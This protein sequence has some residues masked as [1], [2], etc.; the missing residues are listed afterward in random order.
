M[1]RRIAPLVT[2]F[3]AL[4]LMAGPVA[5][6]DPDDLLRRRHRDTHRIAAQARGP[7]S[8][9]VTDNFRVVGMSRLG[10]GVPNGDVFFYD[11]N[12][13]V[14]KYAYVGS[15]SAQCTGAGAKIVDVND[16][17]R[18]RWVGSVGRRADSSSEDIVVRRIGGRDV[19]GIGVQAC[20]RR[21]SDGLAL[22][23]VTNPR[24]P[25]ALSFFPTPGGVHE[26]DLVVR[27]DGRAL[28]LLATPYTEF[29]DTYFGTEL[30]GEFRIVDI[31]NPRAPVA[32]SDWGII[33]DSDLS[34]QVGNDPVSS[35]FQGPPGFFAAHY[36]HSV[37]A[38]DGG[39]TAYVSYWDG[40]ILKFDI[41]NPAAPSYVGRTIYPAGAS[42]DGHSMVPYQVG[43]VRYILQNDEDY[44]TTPD[45]LVTSSA[46]GTAVSDGIQVPWSPRFLTAGGQ[47]KS[48][49]VYDAGDGCQAS[50]YAGAAGRLVLADTVDPF[51]EGI[52]DGWSVPCPIGLQAQMAGAAGAD[53]I[54]FNLISPDDAYGYRPVGSSAGAIAAA[55]P[56]LEVFMIAEIDDVVAGLRA[57]LASGPVTMTVT[58]QPPSWGYLRVF[59]ETASGDW[60]Q[61]GA[62][63]G[64]P[65]AYNEHP[66]P[67]GTWSIHNTEVLGNRA[68]SAWYSNGIVALDLT[69]PTAPRMVGQ[70]VPRTSNRH[71]NSLGRGPAEMW[72]VAIDPETGYIYGSEMR[73]GLWIID[74]TGV[75]EPD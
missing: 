1:L 5:A 27:S 51:Y 66:S 62:F 3:V 29:P 36:V 55:G 43:S 18:P 56:G 72:G 57:A 8:A 14:G 61:V 11:H 71:A 42:G 47:T 68:Y 32:L 33:A 74:P 69:D 60:A 12:G 19:L 30:G 54:V 59:R 15:W 2:T 37:R 52:I 65:H 4:A 53:A 46:T 73:T 9:L 22:Y 39:Q 35:S 75:A 58:A 21:G 41:S 28:A 16:P 6:A 38:A 44:Q 70:F 49:A 25:F 10:G 63:T 31:T 17:S 23:D 67:P 50:D 13:R 20:G 7:A 40:G 48:A 24:R 45:V 26:L 34:I 64:A